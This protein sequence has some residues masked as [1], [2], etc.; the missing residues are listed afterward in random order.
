MAEICAGQ[1]VVL[2]SAIH[3]AMKDTRGKELCTAEYCAQQSVVL[4]NASVVLDSAVRLAVK[5]THNI[6]LP[7][8][9]YYVRQS[10]VL[11][12]AVRSAARGTHSSERSQG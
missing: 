5:D 12:K 7:M 2:V 8:A 11:S 10:T 3:S 4:D 1:S 6:E 9:E